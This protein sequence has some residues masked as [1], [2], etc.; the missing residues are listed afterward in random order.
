VRV[1]VRMDRGNTAASNRA[2]YARAEAIRNALHGLGTGFPVTI[3]AG[4]TTAVV[5]NVLARDTAPVA[6][7]PETGSTVPRWSVVFY[8]DNANTS[9][10]RAALAN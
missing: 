4:D 6:L 1:V 5:S 9:P 7:G 8:V 2:G 3:G 10:E